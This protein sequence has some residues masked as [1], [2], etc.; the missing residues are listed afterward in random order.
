MDNAKDRAE[1]REGE[2]STWGEFSEYYLYYQYS[3]YKLVYETE[4]G[5]MYSSPTHHTGKIKNNVEKRLV[6]SCYVKNRN[7]EA[8]RF[9]VQ[10]QCW[11]HYSLLVF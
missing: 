2:Y 8:S 1:G 10:G 3:A 5:Q 4:Q 9:L 11:Q 7:L 6:N